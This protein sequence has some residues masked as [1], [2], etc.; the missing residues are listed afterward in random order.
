MQTVKDFIN[1][2]QKFPEDWPVIV[3]TKAGGDIVIE[4]REIGGKP[5]I[6]MFGSNG[7]Q[8][9]ENPLTDDEYKKQSQ[10]FLEGIKSGKLYTD[11]HGDDRLYVFRGGQHD[12]CFGTHY[13]PRII[14]RMVDEGLI[15]FEKS[16]W[17][18]TCFVAGNRSDGEK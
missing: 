17:R 3:A 18:K 1:Q 15:Y 16:G 4:H 13:D 14:A 9:G 2:L 10:D 12:T 5:V 8:F 7:G 11:I 6:A